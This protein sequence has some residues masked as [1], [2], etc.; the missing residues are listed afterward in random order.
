MVRSKSAR[1]RR[2][3]L[4]IR[5]ILRCSPRTALLSA[6]LGLGL[7]GKLST[8]FVE[9]LKKDRAADGGGPDSPHLV[10]HAASSPVAAPLGM[11][12]WVVPVRAVAR[13][14]ACGTCSAD[15]PRWHAAAPPLW[16]ASAG[17]SGGTKEPR[18][19]CPRGAAAPACAHADGRRLRTAKRGQTAIERGLA[20]GVV[21]HMGDLGRLH[22]PNLWKN[23]A[24]YS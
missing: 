19:E 7:S 3:L 8:A 14:A 1:R 10:N 23:G 24:T 17:H 21:G 13:I 15:R 6:L 9:R 18:L 12:A 4:G 2:R 22:G 16:P 5:Y 20:G 11:L